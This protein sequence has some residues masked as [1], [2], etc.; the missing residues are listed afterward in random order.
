MSYQSD[1]MA[2]NN[3]MDSLSHY[4]VLGMKWGVR[5]EDTL[6]KYAGPLGRDRKTIRQ[7]KKDAKVYAKAEA[8][9]GAQSRVRKKTVAKDIERKSRKSE[10]YKQAYDEAYDR[11][12]KDKIANKAK[13]S[14]FKDLENAKKETHDPYAMSFVAAIGG[15]TVS[16]L[17]TYALKKT[18]GWYVTPDMQKALDIVLSGTAAISADVITSHRN[19]KIYDARRKLNYSY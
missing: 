13:R 17:S 19:R 15:A 11:I 8:D 7:A 4:G 1:N 2:F 18:T 5:N 3:A 6:R 10:V 16:R 9:Y 12:D 14:Y